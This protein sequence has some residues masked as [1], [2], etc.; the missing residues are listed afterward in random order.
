MAL[1]VAKISHVHSEFMKNGGNSC[2]IS[3]EVAGILGLQG[4]DQFW[5]RSFF[6]IFGSVD[7]KCLLLFMPKSRHKLDISSYI[8]IDGSSS[9]KVNAVFLYK[10]IDQLGSENASLVVHSRVVEISGRK[11]LQIAEEVL[12]IGRL[13]A[14]DLRTDSNTHHCIGFINGQHILLQ[15]E[16]LAKGKQQLLE[17]LISL[18]ALRVIKC[19]I[20]SDGVELRRQQARDDSLHKQPPPAIVDQHG[21]QQPQSL[22]LER[23]QPFKVENVC[24]NG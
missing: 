6:E 8:C 20:E 15:M 11:F 18:Y 4:I 21:L 24:A 12:S 7:Q 3:E 14:L 2:G 19:A 1:H 10:L 5:Y 23:A 22:G 17:F 9:S 16:L 13:D